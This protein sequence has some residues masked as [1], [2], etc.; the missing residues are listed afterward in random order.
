MV[1]V[2][3]IVGVGVAVGVRVAVGVIVALAVGVGVSRTRRLISPQ[4]SPIRRRA[5]ISATVC[6]V[7]RLS[8]YARSISPKPNPWQNQL[9]ISS[10]GTPYSCAKV[11]AFGWRSFPVQL[12]TGVSV[13]V[14]V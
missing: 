7:S 6:P 9:M 5:K 3:V 13:P 12:T 8:P 10:Y 14:G 4:P 1:G 2:G 11:S